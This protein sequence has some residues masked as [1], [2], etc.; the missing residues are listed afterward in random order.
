VLG[1]L[2]ACGRLPALGFR[3]AARTGTSRVGELPV[4]LRAELVRLGLRWLM[5][6]ASRGGLSLERRRRQ[7]AAFER[8]TPMPPTAARTTSGELGGIPALH[9][10]TP[11]SRPDRHI[12]YLHGGGYVCGSP[13]LYRDLLWRFA[14]AGAARVAA[15]SYRLAPEH[16]FPAAIDD[17]LAAWNGLIAKGADPA[18][19]VLM[20]DSAGGGL[21]L[22]LA[23]RLRD[24]GATQPAAVV[25]MSPW[26]DLALGGESLRTNAAADPMLNAGDV[27]ALARLY[28]AG[29]DPRNAYASPLYGDP[30]GLPP[31]LIQVG[32][33]EILRDDSVRMAERLQAAGCTVELEVWRRMPHVWQSFASVMPEARRAIARIGA[34]V[35]QHAGADQVRALRC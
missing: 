17:A 12:L 8:W 25:A 28:L 10:E 29:A 11:A 6:P 27:P 14:S 5:K 3:R 22:A 13:S 1:Y 23:L 30:A 34:F 15:I 2:N 33:D 4:S 26:T 9:V 21:A 32:S 7:I 31:S 19:T 24:A 35:Q 16:P 18:R 20:G